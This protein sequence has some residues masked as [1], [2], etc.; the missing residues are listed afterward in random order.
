MGPICEKKQQGQCIV[1][2]IPFCCFVTIPDGFK[3]KLDRLGSKIICSTIIKDC[4]TISQG[5]RFVKNVEIDTGNCGT[6]FCDLELP[7]AKL[8]GC[9]EVQNAL[10]IKRK[11]RDDN[12]CCANDIDCHKE[13]DCTFVCCETCVCL[14][15]QTLCVCCPQTNVECDATVNF[16]IDK[17]SLDA[18]FVGICDDCCKDEVWKITGLIDIEVD[19]KNKRCHKKPER[20]KDCII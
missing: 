3:P 18:K 9:L 12:G 19:C 1:D 10:K 11:K 6:I 2:P 16:K 4:T 7:T 20:K 5:T 15:E 17:D 8:S 14:E 13:R